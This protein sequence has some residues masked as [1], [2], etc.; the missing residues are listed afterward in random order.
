MLLPVQLLKKEL[1]DIQSALGILGDRQFFVSLT[2]FSLN[3]AV[4]VETETAMVPP[5]MVDARDL[6]A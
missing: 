1:L 3:N 6:L 2:L 4:E 5:L